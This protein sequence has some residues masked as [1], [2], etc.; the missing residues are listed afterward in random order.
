MGYSNLKD[1]ETTRLIILDNIMDNQNLCKLI[2]FDTLTP[3]NEPDI[4][5]TFELLNKRI[6]PVPFIPI[7]LEEQVTT[8]NFFFNR[9]NKDGLYYKDIE[10][11][12]WINSHYDNWQINGNLRPDLIAVEIE[13]MMNYKN[14]FG[15]GKLLFNN[16][17]LFYPADRFAGYE[18][19]YHYTQFN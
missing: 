19:T 18:L 14:G 3:L 4:E 11:K 6:F 10:L 1:L 17:V 7:K 15:I 8:L 5:D 9:I 16:M 13:N 2:A 12:F